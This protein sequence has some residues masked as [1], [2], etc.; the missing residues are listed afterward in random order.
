KIE[1]IISKGHSSPESGW[2]DQDKNEWVIVLKGSAV[3]LF[4][5]DTSVDLKAGDFIDIKAHTKHRVKWTDPD[6][7]TVWLAVHY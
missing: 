4:S 5:D 2:Y 1:R 6:I 7:E 3:L